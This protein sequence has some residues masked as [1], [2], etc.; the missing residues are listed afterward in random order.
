MRETL[1][2]VGA[3]LGFWQPGKSFS[4]YCQNYLFRGIDLHGKSLLDIGCGDGSYMIW[5]AQQGADPVV[6]LEPL[7]E[8]SG[9]SR[10]VQHWFDAEVERL[11]LKNV[12]KLPY[13]LQDFGS[14]NGK[15][16]RVLMTATVNHLDE[17]MCVELK[18]NPKAQEIYL[19]IFE[20]LHGMTQKGGKLIIT[21]CSSRNLFGDLGITNKLNP[22]I[23]WHKHHS[24]KFW[25]KLLAKAGFKDPKID[26]EVNYMTNYFGIYRVPQLMSY[27]TTSGFR[28]VMTA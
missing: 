10:E 26:W 3:K 28:L 4:R 2:K 27:L 25:A 16:D 18:D 7:A 20:Q 12:Q 21:D 14:E 15:F 8:G 6:G 22:K 13:R 9:K 17:E 23:E 19:E 1:R 5:A 24:P 11:N